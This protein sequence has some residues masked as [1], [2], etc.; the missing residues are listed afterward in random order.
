MRD[1]TILRQ[2]PTFEIPPCS[3]IDAVI[4]NDPD[5]APRDAADQRRGSGGRVAGRTATA[6]RSN[7]FEER[8]IELVLYVS[9]ISPHSKTALRNIRRALAQ[10]ANRPFTLTVHDLSKDPQRGALDGVH[11]TP[12]LVTGGTGPRTWIL[13]HLDNRQVLHEFLESAFEQLRG[14]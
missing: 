1:A 3:D 13:G 4:S 2:L 12:T 5:F 8:P 10:F 11:F 14:R 9:S 6:N 7:R